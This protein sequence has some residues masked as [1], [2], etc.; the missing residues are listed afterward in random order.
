MSSRSFRLIT[1]RVRH[2]RQ[3]FGKSAL[4]KALKVTLEEVIVREA[5]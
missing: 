1:A 5:E 4:A 2:L 3:V